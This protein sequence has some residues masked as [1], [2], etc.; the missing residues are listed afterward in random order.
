MARR[1]EF[2][3]GRSKDQQAWLCGGVVTAALELA[4]SLLPS[5]V[6]GLRAPRV[7]GMFLAPLAMQPYPILDELDPLPL[8]KVAS[9]MVE[10]TKVSPLQAPTEERSKNSRGSLLLSR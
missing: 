6:R 8:T 3:A 10:A 9:L 4:N 1:A 5:W 7:S 2:R